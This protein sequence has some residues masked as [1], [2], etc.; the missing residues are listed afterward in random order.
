[1]YDLP[2]F[3]VLDPFL[4]GD[5]F[6][7]RGKDTGYLNDIE[8][9]GLRVTEGEFELTSFSFLLPTPFVRIIFLVPRNIIY[10]V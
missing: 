10:F 2:R 4:H 3:Q 5:D 8:R 6:A 1:M 7:A 9:G